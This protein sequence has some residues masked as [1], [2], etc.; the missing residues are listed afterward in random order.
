M[1]Y[2][3]SL[4]SFP[5]GKFFFGPA[6]PTLGILAGWYYGFKRELSGRQYKNGAIIPLYRWAAASLA[7]VFILSMA[8]QRHWNTN[9]FIL[10]LWYLS[11]GVSL[12]FIGDLLYC[13][14]QIISGAVAS[15]FLGWF[16][17]VLMMCLGILIGV[18]IFAHICLE[19]Y[20]SLMTVVILF[21]SALIITGLVAMFTSPQE[22]WLRRCLCIACC[23]FSA[24]HLL[25]SGSV[26][27][28]C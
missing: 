8:F 22:K 27:T 14:R 23:L 28:G 15:M 3:E 24:V 6:F 10:A 12:F 9:V 4:A 18:V 17:W 2:F 19:V 21:Y 1:I 20:G 13:L 16:M 5:L 26:T 11:C 7:M 25:S